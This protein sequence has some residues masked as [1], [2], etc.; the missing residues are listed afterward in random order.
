MRGGERGGEGGRGGGSCQGW[1]CELSGET[2]SN[3]LLVHIGGCAE[4]NN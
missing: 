1:G 4:D 2:G 3:K